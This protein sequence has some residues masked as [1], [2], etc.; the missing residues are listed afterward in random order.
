MQDCAL[1]GKDVICLHCYPYHSCQGLT[2]GNQSALL[3]AWSWWQ[4]QFHRDCLLVI[5]SRAARISPNY[6]RHRAPIDGSSDL[7]N[8][9][10]DHH[11]ALYLE[12]M[13]LS[14]GISHARCSPLTLAEDFMSMQKANF[15][16]LHSASRPKS[17]PSPQDPDIYT[18]TDWVVYRTH[19]YLGLILYISLGQLV[20]CWMKSLQ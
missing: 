12:T 14:R 15:R 13:T 11:V 4:L 6:D 18:H 7:R 9:Q 3:L 1:S 5:E 10:L 16:A 17:Y 19:L 2:P 8:I 20:C